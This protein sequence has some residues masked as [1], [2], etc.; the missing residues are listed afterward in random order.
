MGLVYSED[1]LLAERT[2]I[3]IYDLI[4]MYNIIATYSNYITDSVASDRARYDLLN[5]SWEL[6]NYGITDA[7]EILLDEFDLDELV[8][9]GNLYNGE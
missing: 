1:Q 9:R 5:I 6:E 4:L 7:S 3:R 2:R 8:K